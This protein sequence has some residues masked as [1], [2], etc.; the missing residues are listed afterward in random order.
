VN[1]KKIYL[2]GIAAYSRTRKGKAC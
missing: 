1:G 2:I